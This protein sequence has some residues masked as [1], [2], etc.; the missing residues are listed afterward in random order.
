MMLFSLYLIRDIPEYAALSELIGV[1]DKDNF[2]RL[3]EYFGGLSIKIPTI[4]ELEDMLY[5]LLLFQLVD[6][7][8]IDYDEAMSIFK[9]KNLNLKKVRADYNKIKS[10]LNTFEFSARDEI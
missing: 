3:C 5:G 7:E 8:K 9:E 4:E 6:I 2:L 1:L 10:I